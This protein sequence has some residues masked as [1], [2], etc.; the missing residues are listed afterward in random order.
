[1][2]RWAT[3]GADAIAENAVSQFHGGAE[4]MNTVTHSPQGRKGNPAVE[5]SATIS[6]T[7]ESAIRIP[8]KTPGQVGLRF[9]L[10]VPG[11]EGDAKPM[12]FNCVAWD[13]AAAKILD[14]GVGAFVRC[15]G[16][17]K[18]TSWID[19]ASGA[20]KSDTEIVVETVEQVNQ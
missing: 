1:M 4:T 20:R 16:R 7:V 6:G 2:L 3:L 19:K 5:N 8:R 18:R 11:H 14:L 15:E 12:R 17:L 9:L 10:S 13:D